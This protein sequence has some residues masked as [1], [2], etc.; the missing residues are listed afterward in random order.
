MYIFQLFIIYLMSKELCVN[1]T[2]FSSFIQELANYMNRIMNDKMEYLSFHWWRVYYED[3][4][5]SYQC[6]LCSALHSNTLPKHKVTAH[7][8]QV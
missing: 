8:V 4:R 6:L 1:K 3:I 2:G 5:T 7:T